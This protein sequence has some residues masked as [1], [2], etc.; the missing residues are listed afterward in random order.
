MLYLLD[1]SVLITAH[2]SY[3]AIDRVPEFWEWLHHVGNAGQVKIP[4]EIFEE[5]KDG[6]KDADK[7]LLYGWIQET[8]NQDALL[9]KEQVDN[10]Q[11]QHAVTAGYAADLMDDEVEQIGRDPFLLAYA[12]V[13]PS[14]RC[15]VTAEVSKP[16]RVRQNRHLPDVC[17][18]LGLK[19]CDI[20]AFNRALEFR[21]GWKKTN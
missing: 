18:T 19:S 14:G 13:N 10:A 11:V 3:Y 2:N 8:V 1:A 7:D 9:L 12:L 6:P 20:F 17:K 5:I 16:K 21:T 4:L 15:I